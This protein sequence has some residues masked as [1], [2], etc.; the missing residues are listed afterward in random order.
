MRYYEIMHTKKETKDQRE[1]RLQTIYGKGPSDDE[2]DEM[3]METARVKNRV[4]RAK[5]EQLSIDA[6]AKL[7]DAGALDPADLED[8]FPWPVSTGSLTEREKDCLAVRASLIAGK[9]LPW[10]NPAKP[11]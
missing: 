2:F 5:A 8:G 10:L 3:E 11:G 9:P 1:M 7:I 6:L 4:D